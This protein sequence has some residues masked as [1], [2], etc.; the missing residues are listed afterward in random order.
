MSEHNPFG[1]KATLE[2][3]SGNYEIFKLSAL[4]GEGKIENLP[5]SIRILL[6][7]CLRNVDG[8]AIKEEDV[9]KLAK[10]DAANVGQTEIPFKP[11]RVILQ[12]F[13][14]VPAVVDLAAMRS[15]HRRR[16]GGDP[17]KINPQVP[18]ELVIDHSVQVDSFGSAESRMI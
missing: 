12:D 17:Q 6:E 5:Y 13:T 3:K 2:T 8:F 1:S 11:S 16:L 14:G 15:A 18:V 7:C 10:W 4:S 9:L